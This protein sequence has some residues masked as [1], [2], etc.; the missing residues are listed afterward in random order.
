M[1]KKLNSAICRIC[2]GRFSPFHKIRASKG[3]KINSIEGMPMSR[4]NRRGK[5]NIAA[6]AI[7]TE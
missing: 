4:C 1:T 7:D 2:A 3:E 5:G 6:P